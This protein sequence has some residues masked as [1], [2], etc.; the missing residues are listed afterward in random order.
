MARRTAARRVLRNPHGH[1]Q[2]VPQFTATEAKNSFG[3]LMSAANEHGAVA[4]TKRN[5][6]EAVLLSIEAYEGLVSKI[7]DPLEAL[8]QE[9]DAIIEKMQSPRSKHAVD[10]LFSAAPADL[11]RAAVKAAR[12][13]RRG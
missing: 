7:P 1:P 8:H 10:A 2:E 6:T 11:G 4:V 9:F 5:A 3:A 12:R 13:S